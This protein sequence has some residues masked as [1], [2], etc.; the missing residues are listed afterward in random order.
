MNKYNLEDDDIEV[1]EEVCEIAEWMIII[2]IIA[3][4]IYVFIRGGILTWIF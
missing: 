2:F 1:A 3:A 4:L